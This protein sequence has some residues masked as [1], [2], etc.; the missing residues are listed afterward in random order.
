MM[1]RKSFDELKIGDT[2]SLSKI[3]SEEDLQL[4]A[5]ISMDNNPIH[6][7]ETFA[8]TTRFKK[9][10]AHGMLVASLIS[11]VLAN[12]LPGPGTIYLSQSLTFRKPVFIGDEI[13]ATVKITEKNAEKKHIKL[14][15]ICINQEEKVVI[16]G[17]A[18]VLYETY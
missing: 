2:A 9:R 10:I 11:S 15:T 7:D 6:L 16:T 17:D 12:K 13:T 3:I 8:K 1:S 4:F 18:L 5:K 14:S